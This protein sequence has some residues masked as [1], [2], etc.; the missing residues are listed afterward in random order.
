MTHYMYGQKISEGTTF[1]RS[2]QDWYTTVPESFTSDGYLT[3][4][5]EA[6]GSG[7]YVA[8]LA[9]KDECAGITFDENAVTGESWCLG[10]AIGSEIDYTAEEISQAW[11]NLSDIGVAEQSNLQVISL[12]TNLTCP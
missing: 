3:G 7:E 11:D 10:K 8:Y 4:K 5:I 12:E 9:S 1:I 2:V 6:D